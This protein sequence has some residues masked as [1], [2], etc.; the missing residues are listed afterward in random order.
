MSK[1]SKT[2]RQEKRNG[3]VPRAQCNLLVCV[4]CYARG[5]VKRSIINQHISGCCI[6]MIEMSLNLDE[7]Q[8]AKKFFVTS[9]LSSGSCGLA[10]S[11][12]QSLLRMG[13]PERLQ[14]FLK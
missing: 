12:L 10:N 9:A 3:R 14:H 5:V 13:W 11:I 1:Q 8:L 6:S 7:R 4:T 2:I